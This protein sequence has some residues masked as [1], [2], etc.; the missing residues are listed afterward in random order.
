MGSA[1]WKSPPLVIAPKLESGE[2]CTVSTF[3]PWEHFP[4]SA[5]TLSNR[6]IYWRLL[7]AHNLG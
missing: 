6:N 1:W 7:E 3:L 5:T 2:F 4:I